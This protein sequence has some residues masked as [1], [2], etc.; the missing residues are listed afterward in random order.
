LV[1]L[2]FIKNFPDP[3]ISEQKYNQSHRSYNLDECE[4][5]KNYRY[6]YYSDDQ[7]N[8][9][10]FRIFVA[11]LECFVQHHNPKAY[12][13]DVS[14]YLIEPPWVGYKPADDYQSG[15]N[16]AYCPKADSEYSFLGWFHDKCFIYLY[17]I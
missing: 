2:R 6:Q 5:D 16:G 7:V 11:N 4:T 14:E 9:S 13:H 17:I 10:K 3:W 8:S 1:F 12:Q 15:K